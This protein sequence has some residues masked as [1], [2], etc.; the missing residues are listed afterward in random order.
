MHGSKALLPSSEVG[1]VS[2]VQVSQQGQPVAWKDTHLIGLH[3]SQV[4]IW[5]LVDHEHI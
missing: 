4:K 3:D 2:R 1:S 5:A